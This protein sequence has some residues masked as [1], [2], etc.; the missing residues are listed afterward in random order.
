MVVFRILITL[1]FLVALVVW[2][3]YEFKR[4]VAV[5]KYWK[6]VAA[7]LIIQFLSSLAANAIGGKLGNFQYHAIGGGVVSFLFYVYLLK[8]YHLR[9]NWRIELVLLF[10]FVSSLG[11]LNELAEYALELLHVEQFTYDLHD[12]WRDFVANTLGALIAWGVYRIIALPNNAAKTSVD[13]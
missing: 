2:L 1:S 6:W 7:A 9:F 8:T 5:F 10:A 13:S 3:Q 4:D 11:V 12:T